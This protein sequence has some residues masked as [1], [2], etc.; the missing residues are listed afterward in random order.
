MEEFNAVLEKETAARMTVQ[1]F[2]LPGGLYALSISPVE[3]NLPSVTGLHRFAQRDLYAT[4]HRVLEPLIPAFPV[5]AEPMC[6]PIIN[7]K[8]VNVLFRAGRNVTSVVWMI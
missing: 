6:A 3:N 2:L 7:C 4:V 1:L 8:L 5:L